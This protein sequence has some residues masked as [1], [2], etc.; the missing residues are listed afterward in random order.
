MVRWIPPPPA[1]F[2]LGRKMAST[3]VRCSKDLL[4]EIPRPP[5]PPPPPPPPAPPAPSSL[6]SEPAAEAWGG[7]P[8]A[9]SEGAAAAQQPNSHLRAQ[10]YR[11]LGGAPAS[12]EV[13]DKLRAL[14]CARASD[15]LSTD[16]D[17]AVLGVA[18]AVVGTVE[19]SRADVLELH[20]LGE[21]S[22]LTSPATARAPAAAQV[23]PG[24]AAYLHDTLA[25]MQPTREPAGWG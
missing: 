5:P 13:V 24:L 14:L 15:D 7:M 18:S 25:R 8:D 16:V 4:R 10:R 20:A 21:E 1:H 6:P 17:A 2:L 23:I 12:G 9:P 22:D 3:S 19:P 11:L